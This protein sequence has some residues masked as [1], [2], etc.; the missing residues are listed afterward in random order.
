MKKM[1]PSFIIC[2]LMFN[3]GLHAD[4]MALQSAPVFTDH[5][6]LQR[7]QRVPVWGVAKPGT[8][9]TVTLGTARGTGVTDAQGAWRVEIGPLPVNAVPAILSITSDHGERRDLQ[10]VLVGEV[11]V[12]SG[13]SNMQLP[14]ASFIGHPND[15]FISTVPD[16]NLE[17]LVN[18]AP[19]PK[20]RLFATVMNNYPL[21]TAKLRWMP[22]TSES[23]KTF[24]A[25]FATMGVTLSRQLN[26]PVGL[27]LVAV[28]GSSASRWLTPQAIADD[29]ACQRAVIQA[30]AT[31]DLAKEQAAYLQALTKYEAAQAAWNQLPE[32]EKKTHKA[33]GKPSPPVEP[34]VGLYTVGDL[35]DG[36]LKPVIGY[37]IRGVLWDQGESG[38]HIRSIDQVAVMGALIASWRKEWG[39]GEFPFVI[40]QK[41][42]GGGCAFDPAD[43]VYGWAADAFKPLP[44]ASGAGGKNGR[45]QTLR[46]AANSRNVTLVPTSDLGGGVHPV[47]KFAYGAR[48]A[49]VI[50]GAVY[51]RPGAWSGPTMTS[52]TVEGAAIRVRFRQ[53]GQGLVARHSDAVQGFAIAEANKKFVWATATIEGDAVVV[54][55]P[56]VTKPLYVRY[57]WDVQI[58]WANLFNRDGFPALSFRTDP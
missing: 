52:C 13:Q 46:I 38:P 56:T 18:G 3:A 5:L 53:V 42:S 29:P 6:V 48:A 33:P 44:T 26:V 19:Y 12:G 4:E 24:S 37:G 15:P 47:N 9:I 8:T 34:G 54:N 17:A 10:D 51:G 45:E 43:R 32:A 39:Q 55:A 40:V 28:G 31:F 11:W 50:L 22:A 58:P 57:A 36:V 27:M 1:V 21:P 30:R 16:H 41:P 49:R 25:Q 14:C 7:D 23:L 20:V 2:A 35:H